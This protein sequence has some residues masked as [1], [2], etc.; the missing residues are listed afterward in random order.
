MLNCLEGA[1]YFHK[2]AWDR[3]VFHGC[4]PFF[5]V[6]G[7]GSLP[8]HHALDNPT[9]FFAQIVAARTSAFLSTSRETSQKNNA[10][11]E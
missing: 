1:L 2:N 4:F 7:F 5:A 9:Q 3:T 11:P 8:Y 10:T 6:F